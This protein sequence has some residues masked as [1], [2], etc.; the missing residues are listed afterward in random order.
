MNTLSSPLKTSCCHT[1]TKLWQKIQ[2]DKHQQQQKHLALQNQKQQ[3]AVVCNQCNSL[4]RQHVHSQ[5]LQCT[6]PLCGQLLTNTLDEYPE[7]N[8]FPDGGSDRDR[9]SNTIVRAT[10]LF[11]CYRPPTTVAT[12]NSVVS[13]TSNVDNCQP[14]SHV[15]DTDMNVVIMEEETTMYDNDDDRGIGDEYDDNNGSQSMIYMTA[16]TADK[17]QR[18]RYSARNKTLRENINWLAIKATVADI[19]KKII[20]D[21]ISYYR[22]ISTQQHL[23]RSQIKYGMLV[24]VMAVA[25]RVNDYPRTIDE[26][27]EMFHVDVTECTL[28][29]KR[30]LALLNEA[31]GDNVFDD[32]KTVFASTTPSHFIDRFIEKASLPFSSAQIQLCHQVAKRISQQELFVENAPSSVTAGILFF[33]AQNTMF[34]PSWHPP[35]EDHTV[36][37]TIQE[38]SSKTTTPLVLKNAA[39]FRKHLSQHVNI[40]EVTINLC[41]KKMMNLKHLLLP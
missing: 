14:K 11:C 25:L 40:S 26:L 19:P 21:A 23:F 24:A 36:F 6:N 15:N 22:R 3:D 13:L 8:T 17:H 31:E 18:P 28:S 4:L 10:N 39:A 1:N 20:N 5:H 38:L 7:W 32:E 34:L 12:K 35:L 30:C 41:T 9:E 27:A 2:K 37:S 29:M 33:V 16:S